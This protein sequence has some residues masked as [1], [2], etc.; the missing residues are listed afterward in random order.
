MA[1]VQWDS[2]R[3]ILQDVV[4]R[5]TRIEQFLAASGLAVPEHIRYGHGVE[6]ANAAPGSFVPSADTPMPPQMY[7]GWRGVPD[8][9]VMLARTGHMIQAIQEYKQLTGVSLKQAK[10]EV[11]NA[12]GRG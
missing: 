1:D 3:P 6:T 7:A 2:L 10:A 5:L 11:E 4:D 9:I 8:E 12:A